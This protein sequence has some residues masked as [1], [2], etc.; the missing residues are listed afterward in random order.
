MTIERDLFIE[1]PVTRRAR[2]TLIGTIA[3]IEP[4]G[5]VIEFAGDAR[6]RPGDQFALRSSATAPWRPGLGR[7]HAGTVIVID[8]TKISCASEHDLLYRVE[9]EVSR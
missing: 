5:T 3:V 4:R 7:V 9:P 8:L 2:V 6:L 1:V